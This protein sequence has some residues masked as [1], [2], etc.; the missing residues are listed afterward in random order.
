[1]KISKR[2]LCEMPSCYAAAVV[3]RNGKAL[4]LLAP[5]APGPCYAFDSGTFIPE[6]VWEKPG[7][8]MSIVQVPG[9]NG[10]FLAIQRF[11]PGFQAQDAE[12]VRVR[13]GEKGWQTTPLFKLPYVHRFGL[14][15]R[16]GINYIL[17][18]TLCTVKTNEKDWSSPGALYAAELP[19]D[20]ETP[21]VLTQIGGGYTRN[22]GFWQIDEHSCLT[23]CDQGIYEILP[24]A[25]RGGKWISFHISQNPVSDIALCDIDGDGA[26]EIVAIEPFHGDKFRI[27]KWSANGCSPM[28]E[29]PGKTN[30]LH[31]VWGGELRGQPVFIGGAR[32]GN[33]E[34]FLLRWQ[35]GKIIS[36]TIDS[37]AGPANISVIHETNRDLILAANHESGEG[38][39]YIIE[40]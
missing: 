16:G 22:H 26:A 2:R 38:A 35:N 27:Y 17:C 25:E 9:T 18:A 3:Q 20:L 10:D 12:I 32:G 23:S 24:P 7:G 34:L 31:V 15:K 14:L 36:E 29:H 30:F 21:I 19:D 13:R 11:F 33:K 39:V 1:M 37:G 5:D 40:D 8:T 6:S 4:F 28:Y